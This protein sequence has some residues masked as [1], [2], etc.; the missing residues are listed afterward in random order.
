MISAHCSLHLL[1]WRDSPASASWVA[2]ITGACNH[3]QLS[4]YFFFL[5]KKIFFAFWDRVS[6]CPRLECSGM[7]LAHC[8]FCLLGSNESP[9]SASWVSRTT[10]TQHHS[11]LVFVY[12]FCI[13]VATGFHQI[14]QDGLNPELRQYACLGLPK[15]WD[16]RREPLLPA[17]FVFLVQMGFR[18]VAQAGL[19]LLTSGDLPTSTSQ[20]AGITGVSHCAQPLNDFSTCHTSLLKQLRHITW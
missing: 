9:A 20:S 19:E 6:L 17:S 5:I 3:T 12:L 8:N 11:Q 4:L 2:G 1:G 13:L 16:Y 15:C 14:G 18:H 10:S 7:I